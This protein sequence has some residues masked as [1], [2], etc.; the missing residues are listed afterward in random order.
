MFENGKNPG[1]LIGNISVVFTYQEEEEEEEE[2]VKVKKKESSEERC[3]PVVIKLGHDFVPL[4][5]NA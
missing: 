5:F 2:E 1:F 4:D 3:L